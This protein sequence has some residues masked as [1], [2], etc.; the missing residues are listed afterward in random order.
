MIKSLKYIAIL[1]FF[2]G[3][4]AKKAIVAEQVATPE[5]NKADEIIANHYKNQLNFETAAIKASFSFENSKQSLDASADVRIK[6]NEIIW[7]NLKVFGLPMAKALI[8]PT[9]VSFYEKLNNVYLEG[10][11]KY[12]S[13]LL[14][15]DL[16]FQKVQNLL[17]GLPMDDLRKE[18]FLAEIAENLFK[19]TNK[20]QAET[21]KSFSFESANYLLKIQD[22]KQPAKNRG[23]VI[24][25]PAYQTIENQFLPTG[26]SIIANQK[27]QVKIEVNYKKIN[28][29]ENLT[30]PYEIPKGYS[31]ININ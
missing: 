25:Y 10:D 30:Y 11:F 21:E 23:I 28:F 29:N 24:S 2:L 7:I 18:D 31:P 8:T 1:L 19:I 9:R 5:K 15:T 3:C 22:L 14:G 27:D 13:E 12:L 4:K 17:L 26:M 20:N 16:N 6:N